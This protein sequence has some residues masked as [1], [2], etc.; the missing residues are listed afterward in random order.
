MSDRERLAEAAGRLETIAAALAAGD[1]EPREEK[2]LAEE[3]L[4]LSA[5]VGELLP[6]VLREAEEAAGA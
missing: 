2:R 3:A 4:E 6:R 1:L 5:A